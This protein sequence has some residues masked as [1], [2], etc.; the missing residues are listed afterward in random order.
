MTDLINLFNYNDARLD[1]KK[2]GK[3]EHGWDGKSTYPTEQ[4]LSFLQLLMI[5]R[6]SVPWVFGTLRR[7]IQFEWKYAQKDHLELEI[8]D[9]RLTLFR[10]AERYYCYDR[11]IQDY[12]NR[13]RILEQIKRWDEGLP[14]LQREN[15]YEET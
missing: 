5:N 4:A 1:I 14:F 12:C 11:D 13:D 8:F 15:S 3:S 2:I 9:N 7:S 6:I 10:V